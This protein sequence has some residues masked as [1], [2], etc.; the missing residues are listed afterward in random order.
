MKLV[1]LATDN[2]GVFAS[3]FQNDMTIA[4]QSQMA[5]LNLTFQTEYTVLAV[6]DNNNDITFKSNEQLATTESVSG[7]NQRNYTTTDYQEFYDDLTYNLNAS[8]ADADHANC[9]ST[10]WNVRDYSDKKRLEFRYAPFFNPMNIYRNGSGAKAYELMTYD[11]TLVNVTTTGTPNF[12]TTI[13]KA[14]GVTATDDRKTAL[15]TYAKMSTGNGILLIRPVTSVDNGSGAQDNGFGIG[16]TKTNLR[17]PDIYELG[18]DIPVASRNFEIRYN[19]PTENYVYIDNGG[20]EKN[21]GV[22]PLLTNG[23]TATDHDI[24][25]FKTLNGRLEGGV[26]QMGIQDYVDLTTGNNWT[27]S[28]TGTT[29]TFDE[30]NLGQIARYRRL[31]PSTP[32][33]EH[34]WEPTSATGWNVYTGANPPV[35]GDTPNT[36]ATINPATGIITIAGTTFNPA[37]IPTLAVTPGAY[38]RKFFDVPIKPGEDLIPY[39]YLRGAE[40]DISVDMFNYSL[41]PWINQDYNIDANNDLIEDSD[42]LGWE[43]TGLD[44]AVSDSSAWTNGVNGTYTAGNIFFGNGQDAFSLPTPVSWQ[45]TK[46]MELTLHSDIWKFLGFND[47]ENGN[48]TKKVAIGQTPVYPID[49]ECWSWYL[50]TIE[51]TVTLSDNYLVESMSLPLDSFDAS[52]ISYP[53]S[54]SIYVNPTTDKRGRRKNILMTIPTN[55]NT[56]GIVEY[57]SNTPIFIDINNAET[58]NAKN[59]NFRILNKDFSPIIQNT[60]TA[61]MTILI[62]KST[63]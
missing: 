3:A 7:L 39:L 18:D 4:P 52:A 48:I 44:F 62:K 43:Q 34:W 56:N 5:L 40:A 37:Q 2:N 55:D 22:P 51:N 35:I 50:G 32:A 28:G 53:T 8:I 45:E 58:I 42:P 12:R 46:V 6:T 11:N 10:Q 16:L 26:L 17:N 25:Y 9:M 59:L 21:S 15:T 14:N 20:D 23:G 61:I 13:K 63:E 54:S 60:E 1:R 24:V 29:E 57:E 47:R 19:R 30:I 38:R 33:L 27:Q 31:Q 36:T 49:T 41:D